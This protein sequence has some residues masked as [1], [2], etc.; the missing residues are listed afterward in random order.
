MSRAGTG[1]NPN[2]DASDEYGSA[3]ASV[4]ARKELATSSG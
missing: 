2:Q 1:T 3:T 4:S